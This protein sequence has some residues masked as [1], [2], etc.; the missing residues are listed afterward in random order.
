MKHQH[1]HTEKYSTNFNLKQMIIIMLLVKK[2][3]LGSKRKKKHFLK[4]KTRS[5][6][7]L[8]AQLSVTTK[9]SQGLN[10]RNVCVQE[11]MS[12]VMCHAL[13]SRLA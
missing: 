8:H 2:L 11:I 3:K 4:M 13:K 10:E 7:V 5:N 1:T 9:H 12:A 6:E